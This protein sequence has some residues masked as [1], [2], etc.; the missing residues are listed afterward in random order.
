[1]LK[2]DCAEDGSW[3]LL[4]KDGREIVMS[5]VSKGDALDYV[6]DLNERWHVDVTLDAGSRVDDYPLAAE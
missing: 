6:R 1:M 4:A 5:F 3:H 2:L